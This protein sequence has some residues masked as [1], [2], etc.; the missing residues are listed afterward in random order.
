MLKEIKISIPEYDKNNGFEFI[1]EDDFEIKVQ[2]D[3]SCVRIL[4]NKDGLLS[5]A[6]HLINLAQ[7]NFDKG[8][9]LHYDD[10]NSLEEGSIELIIEKI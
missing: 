1:W 5:L 7:D 2:Y 6:N 10:Y 9:H 4:A 8:Y 3:D